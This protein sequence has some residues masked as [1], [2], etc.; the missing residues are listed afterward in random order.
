[1]S[2]QITGNLMK[3]S[4]QGSGARD[5]SP[6]EHTVKAMAGRV[7]RLQTDLEGI[8]AEHADTKG[9]L[10]SLELSLQGIKSQV[11]VM[12]SMG[13]AVSRLQQDG[14]KLALE[15]ERTRQE[16]ASRVVTS[17]GYT[18]SESGLRIQ[19]SGM[20]MENLLDHTGMTVRRGGRVILQA[21]HQGVTAPDVTV[22]NFLA[23]AHARFEPYETGTAC[24]Y[25]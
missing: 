13:Q 7:L 25:V 2:R 12:E 5:I 8:R 17:T 18:F 16:G 22:G 4:C 20:E 14:E 11:S 1:M 21:D 15:L 9:N 10:A 24:F 6:A 3:L 23:V 19:K